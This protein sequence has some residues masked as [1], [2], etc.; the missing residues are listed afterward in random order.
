MPPFITIHVSRLDLPS[1]TVMIKNVCLF[2]NMMKGRF[3]VKPV[4][5]R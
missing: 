3:K 2:I 1:L 4:R 5:F